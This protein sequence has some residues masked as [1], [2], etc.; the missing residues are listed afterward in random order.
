MKDKD[1]LKEL[2]ENIVARAKSL[3]LRIFPGTLFLREKTSSQV[4]WDY[5]ND[6]WISFMEIAKEEGSKTILI[7]TEKAKVNM[8]T[9]LHFSHLLG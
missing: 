3:G 6:D 5:S 2:Y 9:T 8:R 4:I 7:G 1:D